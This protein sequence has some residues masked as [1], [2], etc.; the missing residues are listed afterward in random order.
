[1]RDARMAVAA[2]AAAALTGCSG[3]G[4]LPAQAIKITPEAGTESVMECMTQEVQKMGYK[5]MRVDRG[6]G[7]LEAERRDAAPDISRINEYA[8]GD[9]IVVTRL[10][11][12]GAV[13]PLA[14]EPSSF[15][16]E[17]LFNGANQKK[18]APSE[19]VLADAQALSDR[20]RL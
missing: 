8:G 18:R 5:V 1:M 16:M 17:W 20:C 15:I 19:R 2:L 10:K 12:E 13:R 11:A 9:R 14:I 3:G 7:F 6:D 4:T